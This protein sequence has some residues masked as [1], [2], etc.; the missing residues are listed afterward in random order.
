MLT[1]L[2]IDNFACF[3]NFEFRPARTNLLIG[4]NGTGKTTVLEVLGHIIDLNRLGIS[5]E[6]CFPFYRR[7]AWDNRDKQT[8]EIEV[9]HESELFKYIL[10]IDHAKGPSETR[11]TTI[12]REEVTHEGKPL[13]R[14]AQGRVELYKDDYS[15]GPS[16]EFSNKRS[17]LA[18][19]EQS[20]ENNKLVWFLSWLGRIWRF[21]LDPASIK[22]GGVSQGETTGISVLGDNFSSFYRHL[23]QDQPQVTERIKEE[24]GSVISGFDHMRLQPLGDRSKGLFVEFSS[25]ERTPVYPLP[26]SFLSDGQVVLIVLYTILHALGERSTLL[27]IDE[28]DNFVAL[29][30]IQPWLQ[31]LS[32]RREAQAIIISHNPEVIDY[33]AAD[34]T[35][36]FTRRGSGLTRLEEV[37]F[38]YEG[39]L[40]ASEQIARGLI[41]SRNA[42]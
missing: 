13:F 38:S 17:F 23:M 14:F 10:E 27:C 21:H 28:P 2:Y 30:E 12:A 33:L 29:R 1:R 40:K 5:V 31:R 25:A 36:L 18:N 42:G 15:R 20:S 19:I 37:N 39:G 4:D 11:T 32:D 7:T 26:F 41:G 3:V 16:F 9:E 35:F 8:F 6:T 22:R 34:T 24:L